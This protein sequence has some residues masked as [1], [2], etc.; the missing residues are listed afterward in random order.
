MRVATRVPNELPF[1]V[2]AVAVG[3][4]IGAVDSG[5]R[6]NDAGVTAAALF[7]AAGAFAAARPRLWAR[8]GLA[9]GIWT[10]ILNA[11]R[12][13]SW[14]AVGALIFAFLGASAGA[15]LARR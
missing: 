3:L 15:L 14:G 2:A 5:P 7:L 4:A 8:W 10:P 1:L 9:V 13:H 11:A 6:W 12:G